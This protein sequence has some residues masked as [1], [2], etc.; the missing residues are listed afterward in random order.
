MYSKTP[1]ET[2]TQTQVNMQLKINHE[3]KQKEYLKILNEL[4]E[5]HNFLI[6]ENYKSAFF[7]L[8]VLTESIAQKIR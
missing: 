3:Y 4:T 6:K 2:F 7:Q 8:G 5:I 1:E